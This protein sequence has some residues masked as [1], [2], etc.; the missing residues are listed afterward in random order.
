[1]TRKADLKSIETWIKDAYTWYDEVICDEEEG[2]RGISEEM[3]KKTIAK[4]KLNDELQAEIQSWNKVR[5]N[6]QPW[7]ERE[8]KTGRHHPRSNISH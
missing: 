5:R 6:A 1:M 2:M 7:E 3:Q 8:E 4:S